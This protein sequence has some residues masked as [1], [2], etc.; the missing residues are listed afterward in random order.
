MLIRSGRGFGT[1]VIVDPS[2]YVL[3]NHHV[4]ANGEVEDFKVKVTVEIGR[5]TEQGVNTHTA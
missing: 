3:T 1:G 2:G 5:L 4:V